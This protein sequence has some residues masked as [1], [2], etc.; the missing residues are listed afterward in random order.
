M[1]TTEAVSTR[2]SLHILA[3]HVLCAARHA[4]TGRI[5]LRQTPGGFGTPPFPS[6]HGD[7]RLRIDGDELVIE[8]DRGER[9]APIT[10]LR[11]AG[12]L[13]EIAPG[14]PTEVFTPTT[15]L[16]LDAPLVVDAAEAAHLA[17][18][19]LLVNAALE[20]LRSEVGADDDTIIQ[21]WPEHFDLAVTIDEVNFGGSLGD[22]PHPTPYLY[23]GPWSP[24][25]PDGGFWNEPF[26]SSLDSAEVHDATAALA[27]FRRGRQAV[28]DR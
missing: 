12:E 23:V 21:L 8:D 27:Y 19:Y 5:G 2:E 1:T 3:E 28:N 18:W 25:E 13:A 14:A 9:R 4:A 7:R 6:A 24:P 11:S 16:D 10:T 26:G 15:P 20:Q 17:N 22:D